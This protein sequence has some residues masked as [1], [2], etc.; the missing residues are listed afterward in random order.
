MNAQSHKSERFDQG[1]KLLHF[2]ERSYVIQ[3]DLMYS[4]RDPATFAKFIRHCMCYVVRFMHS[5]TKQKRTI[6]V[7]V[8]SVSDAVSAPKSLDRFFLQFGAAYFH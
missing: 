7:V 8:M 3:L 4:F 1:S 5:F 2:Q 6:H